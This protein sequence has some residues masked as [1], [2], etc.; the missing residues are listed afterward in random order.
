[1]SSKCFEP[2]DSSSGRGLY[3]NLWYGAFYMHAQ[4]IIPYL[5]VKPSSWR[6]IIGFETCRRH[7]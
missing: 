1:V 5:Y 3:I 2:E 4:R 7:R 6:W